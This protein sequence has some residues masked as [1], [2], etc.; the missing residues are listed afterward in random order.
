MRNISFSLTAWQIANQKKK[1]TR[2]LGWG[3]LRP[4]DHVRPVLKVRGL[5]KGETVQSI[6]GPLRIVSVRHEALNANKK[7][8]ELYW[9]PRKEGF[10]YLSWD[11]FI[12]MFC[13]ANK[14]KPDTVITRIEFEYTESRRLPG[15]E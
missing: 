5:K 15:K 4:G 12:K 1:V 13:K 8:Y 2:R 3:F 7:Q 6:G 14:C 10:A 11:E 9:E